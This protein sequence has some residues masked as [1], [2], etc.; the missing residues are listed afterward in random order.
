MKCTDKEWQHCRVEKMGCIGCYYDEIKINDYIR[1]HEEI[2]K[3]TKAYKIDDH[4]VYCA[5]YGDG[6]EY[7]QIPIRKITKHGARICDV[8]EEG[9]IIFYKI[10]GF[11]KIYM[12]KVRKYKNG[13]GS[14]Y[15][16]LEQ[17]KILKVITKK[18]LKQIGYEIVEV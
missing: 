11:Q 1:I 3:I 18:E 17:L 14:N 12:G 4:L 15:Y 9:D 8:L 16:G 2:A 6:K 10:N 5:K 13:L 7:V